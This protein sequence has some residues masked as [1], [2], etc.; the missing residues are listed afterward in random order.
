[1]FKTIAI[2]FGLALV[3]L[4]GCGGGGGGGGGSN[5]PPNANLSNLIVSKATL[6]PVFASGTLS[7]T[8]D[9]SFSVTQVTVT[10][11]ASQNGSTL[12]INGTATNSGVPSA[13][14]ALIVGDTDSTVVVTASDGTTVQT[15]RVVVTRPST[16]LC[17]SEQ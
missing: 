3:A 5:G 12:T 4:V 11:T 8:A 2:P 1:M 17:S 16:T 14:I 13:P 9:V 6:T 7:Y 10:A 15:Y